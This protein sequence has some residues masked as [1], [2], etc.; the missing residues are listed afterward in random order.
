MCQNVCDEFLSAWIKFRANIPTHSGVCFQGEWQKYTRPFLLFSK[1]KGLKGIGHSMSI[2]NLILGVNSVKVSCFTHYDTLLQNLTDII[3][4]CDS[5]FITKCDRS[6][7][8]DASG[9]L[10]QNA[11]VWLQ[12]TTVITNYDNFITKCESY[13][14][15]YTYYKLRQYNC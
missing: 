13:T 8:Q 14:K 6:L 12:N 3:T 7:L 11:I 10:L 4:K 2:G 9:F 1:D 15:C 5:Y